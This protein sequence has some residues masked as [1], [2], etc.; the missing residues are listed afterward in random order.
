M[1]GTP[2][3]EAARQELIAM[4]RQ[5]FENEYARKIMQLQIMG[6]DTGSPQAVDELARVASLHA[7][8]MDRLS[9]R[10]APTNSLEKG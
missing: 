5:R 10:P 9:N 8:E 7:R 4:E 1:T 2:I 3:Q 6:I